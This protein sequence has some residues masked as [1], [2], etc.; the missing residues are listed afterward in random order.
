MF[1]VSVRYTM[2]S[3]ANVR[4]YRLTCHLGAPR[5]SQPTW[6]LDAVST[7]EAHN[8]EF[9]LCQT[10]VFYYRTAS[11]TS[12][13]LALKSL[14]KAIHLCIAEHAQHHVFIHAGVVILNE[15]RHGF[16]RVSAMPENPRWSGISSKQAQF[17]I[18]MSTQYSMNTAAYI[19]LRF[20]S[21]CD[22]DDGSKRLIMPDNV[23]TSQRKPDLIVFAR[24]RSGATWRPTL[25]E[26]SRS[27]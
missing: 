5:S 6:I 17:I 27:L 15:S 26:P 20:R 24:Y 22:L 8:G 25:L 19:R 10:R 1:G 14:Q 4:L 13:E 18:R 12:L 21:V 9:V 23:G 7:V 2:P 3:D 16:S 11:P